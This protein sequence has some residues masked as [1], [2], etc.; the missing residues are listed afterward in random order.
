MYSTP[1]V[2]QVA[3][4]TEAEQDRLAGE[5]AEGAQPPGGRG[6]KDATPSN[7]ASNND[8]DGEGRLFVPLRW[9]VDSLYLSYKGTT[10]PK[11]DHD[12]RKLK[13]IAQSPE[14][15]QQVLAQ[16]RI[17][18]HIFEVRDKG[19]GLF[20][21]VL[22]DNAFRIQVPR[23]ISKALPLAYVQ[24]SSQ[25]LSAFDPKEIE[26]ELYEIANRLG[27]VKEIEPGVSRID[28]FVDFVSDVDMEGWDRTA[29]VTHG[30]SINAYSM[31]GRFSGW[32]VGLGGVIAGRLYDKT[33]EI[34]SSR[35]DYLRELWTQ[36]GWNGAD[37]VWR[38]EF[39]LKRELL[40]QHGVERFNAAMEHRGSL[41]EYATTQWLRL[42]IPNPSDSARSRWLTHPLWR[43]LSAVDWDTPGGPL[44]RRFQ[45]DR[46]PGDDWVFNL[47][48]SA[49]TSYMAREGIFDFELGLRRF[50]ESLSVF[51][52]NKAY[53]LGLLF[54]TYVR[55]KVMVK[56]RKYNTVFNLDE[57]PEEDTLKAGH[58]AAMEYLRKTGKGG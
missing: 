43:A 9:G 12:I 2:Q 1:R 52:E 7:T 31:D 33:L 35:K 55:E 56:A 23:S 11:V 3:S 27:E 54:P 22:V 5:T 41:W 17:L 58:D 14:A 57:I 20:P 16:Y 28:L 50:G 29:W 48:L 49:L 15:H 6:G 26:S 39:E 37:R 40:S 25:Y 10:D 32:T 18:D 51:H 42:T 13:E 19:A 8:N 30:S 45:P 38:L 34:E 24:I 53:T 47:G 36:C 44:S 21:Y 46:A 4:A